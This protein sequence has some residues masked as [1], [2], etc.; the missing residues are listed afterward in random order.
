MYKRKKLK[1]LDIWTAANNS[2]LIMKSE[3]ARAETSGVKRQT[4]SLTQLKS[5]YHPLGRIAL[6]TLS[7]SLV[8]T[9]RDGRSTTEPRHKSQAWKEWTATKDLKR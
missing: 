6:T 7:R 8:V 9:C 5:G 1:L 2:F 3:S 4:G